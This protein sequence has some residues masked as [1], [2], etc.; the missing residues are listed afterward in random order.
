[1]TKINK[2]H[3]TFWAITGELGLYTGFWFTRYEAIVAHSNA[4]R[5]SWKKCYRDGDRAIKVNVIPVT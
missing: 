1:M 2:K 4:L 5:K 3:E